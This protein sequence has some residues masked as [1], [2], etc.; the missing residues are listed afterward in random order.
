MRPVIRRAATAAAATSVLMGG[1][2]LTASPASAAVG[3]GAC[4]RNDANHTIYAPNL[5]WPAVHSG[6]GAGY[7]VTAHVDSAQGFYV[8]CSAKS[9]AGNRWYYGHVEAGSDSGRYGWVWAGNF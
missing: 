5:T 7:K 4:T 1:L 6:T 2:A 9:K 3:S 8:K